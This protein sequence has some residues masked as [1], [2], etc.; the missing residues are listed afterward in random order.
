MTGP[1]PV[2]AG[3][4]P[5]LGS[6]PESQRA[7][8]HRLIA[9]IAGDIGHELKNPIHASVIN[10]E[11]VRKRVA[12]GNK[13]DALAR[14]EV[15]SDQV[16]RLHGVVE[17]LL[18]LLRYG[19]QPNGA[20]ELDRMVEFVLPLLRAQANSAGVA[21][22]WVPAGDGVRSHASAEAL[23]HA[24]VG[25]VAVAVAV[26]RNGGSGEVR[27]EG[28]ATPGQVAVSTRGANGASVPPHDGEGLMELVRR[29]AGDGGFTI[30]DGAGGSDVSWSCTVLLEGDSNA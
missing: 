24:L 2:G 22:E 16:R 17:G 29:V 30:D 5:D 1:R 18:R 13:D 8:R 15:V 12:D 6:G 10:L 19:A 9:R 21:L 3:G 14:L 26:A 27:V 11:L 20:Q 4:Q 28:C 7:A 25:L 23:G